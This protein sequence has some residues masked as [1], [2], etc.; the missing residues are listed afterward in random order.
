MIGAVAQI[1][2]RLCG[3][4]GIE[5]VTSASTFRNEFGDAS[6]VAISDG[7]MAGLMSGAVVVVVVVED[8]GGNVTSTEQVP[9]IA[10][11]PDDDAAL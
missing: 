3:D 7:P 5:N 11:E 1:T 2:V 4:E 10:Q 8:P 9:E 6:G